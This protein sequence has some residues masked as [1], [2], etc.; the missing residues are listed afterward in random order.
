M[1]IPEIGYDYTVEFDIEGAEE[2]KGTV[3]FESPNATFWL[4][5][6]ITGNMAFSREEKLHQ[7]RQNV[8]PGEKLH[9][10]VTGDN[11]GTRLYV[12]GKLVDDMNTRWLSYNGGKTRWQKSAPS[13]FLSK[14]PESSTARLPI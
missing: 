4:S 3:L 7:F 8:L 2:T 14:K 11:K 13:Y 9:V 5:D 6:P 12:N 1:P 10:K